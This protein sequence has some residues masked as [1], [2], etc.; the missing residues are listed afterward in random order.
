MSDDGRTR[1]IGAIA[2][3]L[4]IRL[5]EDDPAFVQVEL[6]RLVLDQILGD[7]ITR[8][9]P[10]LQRIEQ[11]LHRIEQLRLPD[12]A[13]LAE[14]VA[15]LVAKELFKFGQ[16]QRRSESGHFRLDR[17]TAAAAATA[18]ALTLLAAGFYF[19]RTSLR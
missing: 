13:A 3:R 1:L 16:A 10:L 12:D 5:D 8:I 11:L 6:T 9:A 2:A 4:K 14:V 17:T 18:I 7:A 15:A 19:G